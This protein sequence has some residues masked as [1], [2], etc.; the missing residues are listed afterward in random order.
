[1]LLYVLKYLIQQWSL[2]YTRLWFPTWCMDCGSINPDSP[3][4]E[5]GHCSK[6]YPRPFLQETQ[7]GADSYPLYRRRSPENGG[8]VATITINVK[9]N[10]IT[11]EIDNRWIVP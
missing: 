9:G 10:R 7:P 5:H 8:L 2:N 11:Q 3:C 1:M 6:K 4:T